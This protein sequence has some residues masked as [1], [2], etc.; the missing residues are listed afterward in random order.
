MDKSVDKPVDN[1]PCSTWNPQPVDN[2]VDNL[3]ADRD[4]VDNPVDNL[5]VRR[6]PVDNLGITLWITAIQAL[7]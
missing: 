6:L 1:C 5:E 7:E 4:P 2:L 3:E